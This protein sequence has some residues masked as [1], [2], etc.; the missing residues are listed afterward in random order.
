[1]S[2]IARK[3]GDGEL[4]TKG[5]FT[6]AFS[7]FVTVDKVDELTVPEAFTPGQEVLVSSFNHSSHE[8]IGSEALPVGI[9]RVRLTRTHALVDGRFFLDTPGGK[10]TFDTLRQSKGLS[11]W[12]FGYL[13]LGSEERALGNK[14]VRVLTRLKLIEVSPVLNPAN[15]DTAT[16]FID[17]EA[18]DTEALE[19]ARRI[20]Q[21]QG[22]AYHEKLE[23]QRLYLESVRQG[24]G[25]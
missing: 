19:E 17:G 22:K 25:A 3:Q 10:A 24:Y 8:A 23:L 13:V 4:S 11:R 9:G 21:T 2:K 1:M 18:Y 14:R 16:T 6:A 7:S 12:S 5:T 20:L 15:D